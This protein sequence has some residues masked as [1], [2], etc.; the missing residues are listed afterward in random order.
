MPIS[1]EDRLTPE[2]IAEVEKLLSDTSTEP[3]GFI[4]NPLSDHGLCEPTHLNGDMILG[5]NL[6]Y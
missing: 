6:L 3:I 2:Q 5:D 1:D 4:T